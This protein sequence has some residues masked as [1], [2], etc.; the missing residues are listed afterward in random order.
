MSWLNFGR[1]GLELWLNVMVGTPAGNND[2]A[3][4]VSTTPPQLPSSF[5]IVVLDEQYTYN[6]LN[7]HSSCCLW[8]CLMCTLN[9]KSQG[10]KSTKRMTTYCTLAD[11]CCRYGQ[12]YMFFLL[13]TT[14]VAWSMCSAHGELCKNGWT[15]QDAVW[16]L[17]HHHHHHMV[18]LEWPKQQR[19]H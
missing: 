12:C 14:H 5:S 15:D 10:T 1:L 19:H 6:R 7:R 4:K 11:Q 8:E 3:T 13:Q 2:T 18:F 9:Q 17:M 16:G